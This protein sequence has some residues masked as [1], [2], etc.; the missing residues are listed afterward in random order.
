MN[1]LKETH[2]DDLQLF[3]K[4]KV[5]DIYLVRDALLFIATDR[6]SAFDCVMN[7]PIPYKGIVLN[8]LSLFWFHLVKDIIPNHVVASEV[9]DYPK[10]LQKYSDTISRRSVLV[11]RM[12]MIPF[13]FVV[14]GYLYGSAWK[15]Y[16]ENGSV[17]GIPFPPD[18]KFA[19]K[20]NEP[21][22]T[23]ATKAD[24]G[25]DINVSEQYLADKIGSEL[26][27]RLKEL[28]FAI[29]EKASNYGNEVGVLIADTKFEFGLDGDQIYL[30]DELLTPDSSRF[31][32]KEK[33]AE[34]I[35]QDSLDKQVVRDYLNTT[36]WDK[37]PP[38]P[39]LPPEIVQET[40]QRYLQIYR[41]ITGKDL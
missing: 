10:E 33:Y 4:G 7:E 9:K 1:S 28:S 38:P 20:L 13:E 41:I 8:M 26:A 23:P 25:H 24:T 5:R 32:L 11:K 14:R 16:Q 35:I 29:F 31:W 6:L 2:F 15:D 21:I 19:Q 37:N 34:G 36:G 27:K 30:C 17:C 12:S 18:L 39:P 22:F 3:S 40:S